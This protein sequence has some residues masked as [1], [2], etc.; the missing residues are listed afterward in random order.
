V[1]T[2]WTSMAG[3][4]NPKPFWISTRSLATATTSPSSPRTRKPTLGA[5]TPTGSWAP[6]AGSRICAAIRTRVPFW[7]KTLC[8]PTTLP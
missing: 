5:T 2:P 4:L 7:W 3:P 6:A 1:P 8:I